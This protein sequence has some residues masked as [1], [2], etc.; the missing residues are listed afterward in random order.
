MAVTFSV[1]QLDDE[2]AASF[3][4][5]WAV[6]RHETGRSDRYTSRIFV[7][8]QDAREHARRLTMQEAVRVRK[9]AGSS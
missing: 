1:T 5:G 4:S 3:T 9:S 2:L 6:I 7:R 8:E